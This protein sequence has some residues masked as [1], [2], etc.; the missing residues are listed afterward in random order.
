MKILD[1][2]QYQNRRNILFQN[3]EENSVLLVGGETEKVRNNDVNF[4]FRQDSI[5][6]YLTGIE[7]ADALM[8]MLKKDSEKYILFLQ[9]KKI[10]EEVWTGYKIGNEK[11]KSFYLANDSY[12]NDETERFIEILLSCEKI[13]YNLGSSEKIDKLIIEGLEQFKK[14]KSR[15]GIPNPMIIDPSVLIDL[16]RLKKSN[17]E[18]NVLQ[19][20]IDITSNGFRE[21]IKKTSIGLFEYEVQEILEKEFR[22]SGAKRNGYPSIVA[23]GRN[24]CILHYVSNNKQLEDNDLILIDAGSEWDYYS[25]DITRTWPVN[26][27]FTSEQKDIYEIVLQA[28]IDAISECKLGNSIND[29]HKKALKTLIQGLKHLGILKESLDEIIE[30]RLY[31]PFYMH[32]TS[33]WLG[34]DVHDAGSY[35]DVEENYTKFEE[36][37]ILTIEPGLYFGDMAQKITKKYSNIGIRIEDNILI[38][39]SGPKN[40]SANIP[41]DIKDMER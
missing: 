7:E 25:A 5:F 32:S 41:K 28:N 16:M 8:M 30:K 12:K 29:P 40:L 13:Y 37:M 11:A 21:A 10:E 26:G 4:D 38:D 39:A 3:M 9:E 34:L 33:H 20:A 35:R 18:I 36:G 17:E 24:A 1:Q 27:T 6:W 22:M 19:K 15:I 23:S 31:F 2:K 14:I